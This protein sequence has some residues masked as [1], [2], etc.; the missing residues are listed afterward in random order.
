[1]DSLRHELMLHSND[2]VR[3]LCNVKLCAERNGQVRSLYQVKIFFVEK[4]QSQAT[5]VPAL[6]PWL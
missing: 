1:M 5:V 2:V 3:R 6:T 4:Y